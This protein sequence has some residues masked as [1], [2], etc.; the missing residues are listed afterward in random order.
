MPWAG[1]P[2]PIAP[3]LT[4]LEKRASASRAAYSVSSYTSMSLGGLLGGKL[5]GETEARRVLLRHVPEG[6]LFFPEILQA[7]RRPH[8]RRRSPRLLQGRRRSTGVRR[9]RSS[10][11]SR[12]RTRP[13]RT[14]PRPR[15]EALA[16]QLLS[17]DACD[18]GASSRG[19]I[20]STRTTSTSRTSRDRPWG[21]TPRDRY[22][23]EVTFT[24]QYIGKLLDFI[25]AQPWGARTGDHRHA[26]TTA[27]RSASTAVQPRLRALGEPRA[28]A[29]LL[30]R[31]GRAA[32]PTSTS[33]R[34]RDGP[35]A[36]QS[37]ISSACPRPRREPTFEGH[38]PRPR[39]LRR[40]GARRDVVLDLPDDQRQRAAARA[41]P[42]ARQ[43]H[44]LRE[45]N[46]FQL[47]DLAADPTEEHPITKG[48]R[49][50]RRC[51]R[52]TARSRRP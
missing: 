46:V 44:L 39:D 41:R 19:S 27:R 35:R 26:P 36:R 43:A 52:A 9:W 37:S 20:S 40:A 8:A 13:T 15:Q 51:R 2:R 31:A 42:R 34:E 22:D 6:G 5:P 11:T 16:E 25:A 33:P 21:K 18:E 12:S 1:Y 48:R 23:G 17:E 4:E 7:A 14:S 28:R 10:P 32:A 50:R 45:D 29:A 30:R 24:D 3:R 47:F 38:E 49:L